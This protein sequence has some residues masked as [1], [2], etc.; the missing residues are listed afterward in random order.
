MVFFLVVVERVSGHGDWGVNGVVL[1]VGW[2]LVEGAFCGWWPGKL[3]A[4]SG[5]LN[6]WTY[7][8]KPGRLGGLLRGRMG[9]GF[10]VLIRGRIPAG[11]I[12]DV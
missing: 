4:Y 2:V 1:C 7:S 10:R 5:R 3:W 6:P 8:G 12:R 9:S 11:L